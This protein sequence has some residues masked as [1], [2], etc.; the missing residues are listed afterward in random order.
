MVHLKIIFPPKKCSCFCNQKIES[1][2][3]ADNL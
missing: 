2:S 1:D 3:A